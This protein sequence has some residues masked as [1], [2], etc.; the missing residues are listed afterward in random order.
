LN[1]SSKSAGRPVRVEDVAREAGVSPITVSRALSSPD[2]VRPETRARVA[3][4]VARTGYV[5]NSIASSLRSGRSSIVTVFAANLQNPHFAGAMQGA[6]DA[7]EGSRFHLMFAQTG[8]AE[9][10]GASVI[11]STLPFRP[12]GVIFTGLV[13][14]EQAR[15]VLTRL[16]VPLVEMWGNADNPIDMMVGSSGFAGGRLMG[17]H[18]GAQGFRR[19]AYCGNTRERGNER[20][21]GF[22]AGLAE[23]GTAPALVLPR[24]GTRSFSEGMAAVD[25]VLAALPDCD[26]MFFGTDLL[27]V[28]AVLRARHLGIEVPGQ[29]ALAGYGDLEFAEHIDPPLTSVHASDYQLGRHAGGM[30]LK[31]L[32]GQAVPELVIQVPVSLEVRA[33]T[34][35]N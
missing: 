32:T 16:G 28:G 13:G 5:V 30:L 22:I 3:E 2:K 10:L 11:E 21:E 6:L 8:D 34:L 12:A 31:R 7:F 4:A 17:E 35:R 27:A 1:D 23:H 26:A 29:L 33:S 18:F 9:E 20:L 24:S 19:I 15:A 14:N 25:E